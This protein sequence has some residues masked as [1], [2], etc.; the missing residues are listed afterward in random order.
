MWAYSTIAKIGARKGRNIMK[1]LETG[2][3]HVGF[4]V[5][6]LQ[7]PELFDRVTRHAEGARVQGLMALAKWHEVT[8]V[9]L[10]SDKTTTPEEQYAKARAALDAKFAPKIDVKAVTQEKIE[11]VGILMAR[12][13]ADK[14]LR[15]NGK[16][17]VIK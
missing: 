4:E 14:A 5:S 7:Y 11:A 15:G 2:V 8:I 9:I 12:A 13:K 6:R 3:V 1:A 16:V 10:P 17:V